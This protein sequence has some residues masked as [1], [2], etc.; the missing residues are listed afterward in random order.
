[1]AQIRLQYLHLQQRVFL[2]ATLCFCIGIRST[3]QETKFNEAP[4]ADKAILALLANRPTT[5]EEIDSSFGFFKRDTLLLLKFRDTA[6][7]ENYQDGKVYALNMLGTYF[8]NKSDYKKA[9][10]YH[11]EALA[12]SK[13]IKNTSLTIN[14]L[15]MLGVVYRRMDAV[16]TALDYN[17]RALEMADTVKNKTHHIYRSIN[18]SLNC[19]GNIY[20]SLEQYDLAIDYFQR[21]LKSEGDLGNKLGLAINNQNIGDCYEY[22]GDLETALDYNRRSLAINDEMDNTYGRII[23]K[24]SIAQIYLKQQQPKAAK[25]LLEQLVE[26]IKNIGDKFI[27]SN[28]MINLGWANMELGAINVAEKY[29]LDGLGM[30]VD[31][32]ITGQIIYG[33]KLLSELETKRKNYEKAL[34]YFKAA[35]RIESDVKNGQNLRYINDLITRYDAERKANEIA[36]LNAENEL[37]NLRLRKNQTTILIS[38]LLVILVITILLIMYRNRQSNYEKRV[39]GLEQ[40]MLRSQMNPHFLFNS[41]NSIKLYIINNDKKN[42]VHYLN[43]FSKLVRRILDGSTL[44][45]TTL[46]EELETVD[47]YI[48]IENIRFSEEISYEVVIKDDLNPEN[49]KIPSLLLQPFLENAIWHGLSSKEGFKKITV[50]VEK[51][52]DY[53]ITLSIMDNGVGRAKSQKIK[54]KRVIKRKSVGIDITKERLANFSKDYQHGYSVN[55]IDLYD[56]KSNPSGT[57]VVL[58]IPI[59]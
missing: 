41:L 4:S 50:T 58:E 53:H 44:K 39:I 59:Y 30:A 47:L 18:I 35:E 54:E 49:I 36:E 51:L 38:T 24:N 13:D 3:A 45:E 1:M 20:Q 40:N 28:V 25:D 26:P 27:W 37:I 46:A 52:N 21:A 23:C 10:T 57:K 43:K 11:E 5:Y 34:T 9:I 12:L 56:E 31:K 16:K 8:R 19:I 15:N 6:H 32:N 33:N 14:S 7:A 17:Q 2:I 55:I 29:M 48:N 42:A 22:K